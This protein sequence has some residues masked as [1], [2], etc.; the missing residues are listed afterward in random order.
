MNDPRSCLRRRTVLATVSLS[1]TTGCLRLTQDG[2]S[3]AGTDQDDPSN[4]SD[5]SGDSPGADDSQSSG[6]PDA[7]V[8][9]GPAG[10]LRF[11]PEKA[12]VAPGATIRWV[13]E[14]DGHNIVVDAQPDDADWNGTGSESR[15]DH[16]HEHEHTF[17]VP[18]TY[19]YRCRPHAAAGMEGTVVVS[20][21]SGGASYQ[22]YTDI[23]DVEDDW[24]QFAVDAANTGSASTPG[25][26][27]LL[28]AWRYQ[29]S[30]GTKSNL[31]PVVGD[32]RLF[33]ATADSVVALDAASGAV[34]WVRGL[35]ES[36]V[37]GTPTVTG[38]HL[39][40]P[41][42]DGLSAHD[43]A[44]GSE[45]WSA[46]IG[47]PSYSAVC[48]R[49]DVLALST[50]TDEQTSVVQLLEEADGA[51]RWTHELDDYAA[52]P[53][54]MDGSTVYAASVRPNLVALDVDS[55]E[56]RWTHES[57]VEGSTS[58]ITDDLVIQPT[59]GGSVRAVSTADGTVAWE[60]Y[61]GDT[62]WS[63]AVADGTV[64]GTA[65][66]DDEDRLWSLDLASGTERWQTDISGRA[67]YSPAVADGRV[68]TSEHLTVRAY[69]L[70][71]GSLV[72]ERTL[73]TSKELTMPVVA[74]GAVFVGGREIH[75]LA[76]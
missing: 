59:R 46:S 11:D 8:A 37:Q 66:V 70:G 28:P 9:V 31:P 48:A 17:D 27:R 14:S 44:S 49:D 43:P 22:S 7:R 47:S 72:S 67:P 64:V 29:P 68:Y 18:G 16:G 3:T 19:R 5:G 56:V 42:D 13:W 25:P 33:A 71:D 75:A 30:E 62:A 32:G 58:T 57:D 10:E 26:E 4:A 53:V 54:A 2:T 23:D 35:G 12:V 76:D 6:T 45:R 15:Y 63:V 1:A 69:S 20:E 52:D 51:V 34:E 73:E 41:R 55:G 21:S 65:T 61:V 24:R 60:R 36:T 74:D 39:V 38:R 50:T 40:V